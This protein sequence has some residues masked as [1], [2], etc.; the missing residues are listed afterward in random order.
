[1]LE[2]FD[3]TIVGGGPAG[4]YSAFYSGLRSMKTKIIEFQ[5]QLGGKVHLYPEKVIWDVGGMKPILGQDFVQQLVEQGLTFQPTVCLNT[6]VE[7]LAKE[8]GHFT[9]T[10]DDGEKHYTKSIIMANGGGIF[11]PQKLDIEGAQKFEMTNLHYT[12]QRLERFRH[13]HVL[14]SGGGNAAIDWA[15]ELYHL[16]ASVT[17]IY[18]KDQLT[19]HE[20]Q[21][22]MLK[23]HGV[24]IMLNSSIASL[25]SNED[26][27][28][29]EKV[30]IRTQHDELILNVDEVL[31]NHGYNLE[32][33]FE[34]E[35][36]IQPELKDNHYYVG[37]AKGTT[38]IAGIF[39][40]G[41]IISYEGKVNLLVGTFQDAV[42]AVNSAKKYIEPSAYEQAMVSSHNEVF[43]ARNKQF[44]KDKLEV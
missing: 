9:I 17:V 24:N 5:P 27:T 1:M 41:D 12:V 2:L 37:S 3:V 4:L 23:E 20:A 34:F 13:K 22:N 39:A 8:N 11:S 25:I 21:V 38:S 14:I 16:A 10:T 7:Y 40:A 32:K 18:R 26:K 29:I 30:V 28:A 42:N 19:A 43:K 15:V 31:I 33:S 44:I 35:E 6:K 36:S